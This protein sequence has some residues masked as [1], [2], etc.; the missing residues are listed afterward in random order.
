MSESK[1]KPK[2]KSEPKAK[3]KSSKKKKES[4]EE[5]PDFKYMDE[6]KLKNAQ[7][8]QFCPKCRELINLSGAHGDLSRTCSACTWE[9]RVKVSEYSLIHLE[10]MRVQ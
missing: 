5:I 3:A 10:K 2:S 4:K 9:E 7:E 8:P 1:K 6:N